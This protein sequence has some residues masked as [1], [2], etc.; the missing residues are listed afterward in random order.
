M[1]N[2]IMTSLENLSVF[3]YWVIFFVV[4]FA[5]VYFAELMAIKF[6]QPIARFFISISK[7]VINGI[8]DNE[9]IQKIFVAYPRLSAFLERRLDRTHFLGF[10]LTMLALMFLYVLFLFSGVVDGILRMGTIVFVDTRVDNL[11]IIFRDQTLTT[12][13][14]WVTVLGRGHVVLFFIITTTVFLWLWRKRYYII[15][16]YVTLFGSELFTYLGKIIFQRARPESAIYFEPTYS[17]PSG[18]ATTAVAFY[19]F[20]TY[21]LI[22]L[23]KRRRQK[24]NIF[25]AGFVLIFLID[26]SRLYLGVHY[27]SDVWG[28]NLVG[29]LWLIVGISMV[30]WAKNKIG[31]GPKVLPFAQKKK[32]AALLILVS[33]AVYVVSVFYYQ[34]E[35]MTVHPPIQEKIITNI[36]D[37]FYKQDLKYTETLSGAKQEPLS[38]IILIDND[39]SLISIFERADW[40]LADRINLHTTMKTAKTA[41]AK[42]PYHTA[43]M[44]PSFWNLEVHNFGFEKA[45]QANN[46]RQ[47]H[48]ARFWRTGYKTTD[49]QQIYVGTASLDSGIKWGITHKISPDIDT[50]RDYL[51]AGLLRANPE[52]EYVKKPFVDPVLGQNFVG[53]QFFS[54]G[55]AYFLK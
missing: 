6:G 45:T 46:A 9:Y 51:L 43:P 37:I 40:N 53:D 18:H 39:E 29:L 33:L 28:G 42:E 4:F 12:F 32:T 30:E 47:R 55:Q 17:F 50:E 22:H 34:P 44:T 23:A 36:E 16:F 35:L 25:F 26:F 10:P 27:L 2:E 48:H 31:K 52:I 24:I 7:S 21:L 19:G 49:G 41:I 1:L 3:N 54:D 14:T 15:P 13:F 20:I 8:V 5:F 11:L 38:F